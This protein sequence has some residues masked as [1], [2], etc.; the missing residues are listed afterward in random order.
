VP[1]EANWDW[2]LCRFRN[3]P[4]RPIGQ[5]D[6][7]STLK[8]LMELLMAS[9]SYRGDHSRG[10]PYLWSSTGRSLVGTFLAVMVEYGVRL[11]E[12]AP[13]VVLQIGA[14]R[15]TLL[16]AGHIGPRTAPLPVTRDHPL[17]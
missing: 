3:P 10:P 5:D 11:G 17:A 14:T 16:S 9:G 4:L 8:L 12:H 1:A 7:R 15:V 6:L 2:V 13:G